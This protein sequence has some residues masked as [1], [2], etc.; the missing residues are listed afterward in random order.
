MKRFRLQLLIAFLVVL[1][2]A[3]LMGIVYIVFG[4]AEMDIHPGVI[5]SKP[6]PVSVPMRPMRSVSLLRPSGRIHSYPTATIPHSSETQKPAMPSTYG[7]YTTSSAQAHT[8]GSG[9]GNGNGFATTGRSSERG[10]RTNVSMPMTTFVAIASQR[11]VA[12]P[13]A[14]EA[15]AMAQLVSGPRRAPGPPTVT[16]LEEKDQLVEH[17]VPAGGVYAL[18]VM[19]CLYAMIIR[20]KK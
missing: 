15:P 11:Q 12:A 4:K 8:I 6:S 13:E 7:L 1:C 16:D 9:T 3:S 19:G 18:G 2:G 10:I 5:V 20:R 17:P 14:Q